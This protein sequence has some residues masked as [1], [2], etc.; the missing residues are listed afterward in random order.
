MIKYDIYIFVT[1]ELSKLEKLKDGQSNIIEIDI[2]DR[3]RVSDEKNERNDI[4]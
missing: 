4:N 3:V 1:S 2:I